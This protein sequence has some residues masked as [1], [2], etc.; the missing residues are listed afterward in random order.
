MRSLNAHLV[1]SESHERLPFHPDCPI[2]QT[3]LAGSLPRGGF[4]PVRAQ[5][6]IATGLIAASTVAPSAALAVEQ[7][8]EREGTSPAAQ[9]EGG[10][11]AGEIAFD[12]GGAATA[13]P[14]APPSGPPTAEPPEGPAP[15]GT[16]NGNP[17][18][19]IV[20]DGDGTGPAVGEVTSP[21]GTSG[22]SPAVEAAPSV[23]TT[24]PPSPVTPPEPVNDASPAPSEPSEA[25]AIEPSRAPE[26]SS[27]EHRT[28]RAASAPVAPV[29]APRALP[30]A[31]QPTSATPSVPPAPRSPAEP[32][33]TSHVVEPG[34]SLWA[35]AAD[36]LGDEASPARIAREVHR[37]W[38]LN[39][40]RI[41][42][43]NPDLL[44]IG[45]ELSLR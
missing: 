16:S 40:D 10:N 33:D 32:G 44:M 2:C 45:T 31:S 12:P 14:E 35:I 28:R 27:T 25:Q 6:A 29:P 22:P 21:P 8:Q 9:A 41:G 15:S 5:A 4:V 11:P 43:G 1:E 38:Q 24:P 13:L 7:D 3:R 42:T 30:V 18:E 37:L 39:R 19:A 36:L 20:D 34:E 23:V 26:S 17:T